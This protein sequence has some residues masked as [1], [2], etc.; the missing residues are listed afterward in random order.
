MMSKTERVT[1]WT[2]WFIAGVSA[3]NHGS[4][5]AHSPAHTRLDLKLLGT[6][7]HPLGPV[8]LSI[9]VILCSSTIQLSSSGFT[10]LGGL[11]HHLVALVFDVP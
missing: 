11:S 5:L 10:L 7:F 4:G 9:D 8:A 1:T 3:E 2:S 6:G